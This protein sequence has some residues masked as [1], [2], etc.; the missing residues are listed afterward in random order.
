M[1]LRLVIGI[2]VILALVCSPVIA[3]SSS[4]LIAQYQ[5]HST[6]LVETLEFDEDTPLGPYAPPYPWYLT[7]V[8]PIPAIEPTTIPT[9]VIPSSYVPRDGTMFKDVPR[10]G[11]MFKD[12]LRDLNEGGAP[13]IEFSDETSYSLTLFEKN[14]MDEPPPAPWSAFDILRVR[15]IL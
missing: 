6:E 10:D 13:R 14:V 4:D 5:H 12:W 2:V 8:I 9:P 11:T 1:K 7:P 15:G 3:I